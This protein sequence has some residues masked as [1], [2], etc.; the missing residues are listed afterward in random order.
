[1]RPRSLRSIG[2][3]LAKSTLG[4][5][6]RPSA[7]PPPAAGALP[8]P[9]LGARFALHH[10]LGEG[11]H[12]LQRDAALGTGALHLFQRH[13]EF[14]REL[15]HRGRRMRQ[16]A[17]SAR[18]GSCGGSAAVGG[19]ACGGCGAWRSLDCRALP[20]RGRVG[21]RRRGAE[22][23]CRRGARAVPS[24]TA[25]RSPMFTLSPSLTFS[26]FTDAGSR[27]RNLH[28][29]LVRFHRDQRLLGLD[30][31]AGLDQQLD[32]GDVLEVA[33]VGDADFDGPAAAAS[34][35]AGVAGQGF[36]PF[37]REAGCGAWGWGGSPL[38]SRRC[39]GAVPARRF[40]APPEPILHSP[41]RRA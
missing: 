21:V 23:A 41:C 27:R 18:P 7:S 1:M 12:V 10:G 25:I 28:R 19:R 13:A 17:R 31:V 16:L 32:D 40:Q 20:L 36:T 35:R 30:R 29:G 3:N 9:A 38:V 37:A 11:L 14:A 8:A 2:P 24:S 4:Q 34:G 6:S 39:E 15:A 26:S 5:G 33:D 22:L